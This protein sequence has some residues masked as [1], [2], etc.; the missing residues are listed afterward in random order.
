MS[1]AR[2]KTIA[3]IEEK[4]SQI[5]PHSPRALVLESARVF[6]TTWVELGSR[7]AEVMDKKLYTD[8]GYDSFD[9]YITAELQIKRETA[10]KLVRTFTF[11]RETKPD[12]LNPEKRNE[13]PQLNVVDFIQKKREAEEV[14]PEELNT[15]TEQAF[16]NQWSPRTV[17]AR[18]RDLVS[19]AHVATM[20][21]DKSARA[22]RRAK[23][24]A[25]RLSKALIEIPGLD[26]VVLDSLNDIVKRLD[27]GL[28]AAGG[29]ATA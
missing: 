19:D 9:R 29:E 28:E 7:L 27:D 24:L 12:F 6:K 18:W 15:F 14:P 20:P 17:T 26:P 10:Y 3:A 5:E 23:E 8:W 22:I 16:E 25:E 2:S 4:L 21:E 11:V 1:A 13:L